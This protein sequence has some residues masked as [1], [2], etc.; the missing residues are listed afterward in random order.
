[1][2]LD[3]ELVKEYLPVDVVIP[4]IMKLYEDMLGVQSFPVKDATTW[5]EDVTVW[6]VWDKEGLEGSKPEDAFQGYLYLDLFPREAKVSRPR[7]QGE[8]F[9]HKSDLL[10]VPPDLVRP[11]RS[12]G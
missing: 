4:R 12:M 10:L 1:M 6:A 11:C 7:R 5:H 8:D 3:D 2:K 9:R